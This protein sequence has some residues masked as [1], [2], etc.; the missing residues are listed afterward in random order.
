MKVYPTS[1]ILLWIASLTWSAKPSTAQE[2]SESTTGVFLKSVAL[3]DD[4]ESKFTSIVVDRELYSG[5]TD[6]WKDLRLLNQH[7]K[8]VPFLLYRKVKEERKVQH[9]PK[10]VTQP[11]VRPLDDGGLE[12]IFSVDRQKQNHSIDGI[13]LSTRLRDFEHR[14]TVETR[15]SDTSPWRTLVSNAVI[16]DY[17]RYMDI[18]NLEVAFADRSFNTDETEFRIVIEKVTQTKE[19]QFLELTRTVKDGVEDQLQEKLTIN[20]ENFKLDS[21]SY[22]HSVETIVSSEPVLTEYP[23][24]IESRYEDEKSKATV[25]D[26]TSNREPLRQIQL[27][28]EDDNFYRTVSFYAVDDIP[29]SLNQRNGER[30]LTR[31]SVTQIS[32]PN[33]SRSDLTVDFPVVRSKRYRLVIENGD[34]PPLQDIQLKAQGETR[35]ILFFAQAEQRYSVVYGNTLLETPKYD[36]LAIQAAIE[37]KMQPAVGTLDAATP[38]KLVDPRSEWEKILENRWLL[39][40]LFAF[41]LMVLALTLRQA[42]KRLASISPS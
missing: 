1:I 5:T 40:T 9:I 41:L 26:C 2:T 7:E 16:Y 42:S 4:S 32:L 28:T 39:G 25:I 19:S 12:I 37:S 38:Y 34:S 27:I 23:L 6:S 20:R 31:S 17:S 11:R 21:I 30:L 24:Q 15:T 33:I 8:E 22:W 29:T 36:I 13:T 35:E 3:S 18:R 14:V 10:L